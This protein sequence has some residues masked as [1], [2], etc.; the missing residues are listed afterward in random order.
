MLEEEATPMELQTAHE[1]REHSLT[2]GTIVG[3]G[4]RVFFPTTTTTHL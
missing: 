4:T 1:R 2:D 3:P